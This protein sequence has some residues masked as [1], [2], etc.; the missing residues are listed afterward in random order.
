MQP[1]DPARAAKDDAAGNPAARRRETA[2][3]IRAWAT[4]DVMLARGAARYRREQD[5]PRLLPGLM[6]EAALTGVEPGDIIARLKEALA[7]ERA[8][9]QRGHRAY[10]LTRHMALA[11]ALRAER[12]SVSERNPAG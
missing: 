8:L 4:V 7:R 11:Q 5:L 1:K 2:L 6:A 9:G 12:S 3:K 10:N